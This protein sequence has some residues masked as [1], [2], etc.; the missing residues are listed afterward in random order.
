MRY[1]Y[2]KNYEDRNKDVEINNNDKVY[3]LIN[4]FNR[5]HKDAEINR[6]VVKML[7]QQI[8]SNEENE[9][10]YTNGPANKIQVLY[11]SKRKVYESIFNFRNDFNP[12]TVNNFEKLIV[13]MDGLAKTISNLLYDN[14]IKEFLE[15]TYKNDKKT[16]TSL[17]N[18][19]NDLITDYK[20]SCFNKIGFSNTNEYIESLNNTLK[21]G[22]SL[23]NRLYNN[24][25][26]NLNGKGGEAYVING[27]AKDVSVNDYL[28]LKEY[29]N[30]KNPI[31]RFFS[32]GT[33]SL[34]SQYE[35]KIKKMLDTT[36]DIDF[37]NYIN[38]N[39]NMSKKAE[40]Y[41][42]NNKLTKED[43]INF[44]K[45]L[46][47]ITKDLD[48]HEEKTNEKLNNMIFKS[49]LDLAKDINKANQKAKQKN[50]NSK[51]EVYDIMSSKDANE[52]KD[53][54]DKTFEQ[55]NNDLYEKLDKD[56][57][58]ATDNRKLF[59]LS[60]ND[61]AKEYDKEFGG[62][63][64]EEKQTELNNGTIEKINS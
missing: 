9:L 5:E 13:D 41:L 50:K 40:K 1:Q 64:T 8:E 57:K 11:Y 35:K 52:M 12:S 10:S 22:E 38:K 32:F 47:K 21:K 2:K 27:F 29:L 33:K 4:R 43:I 59:E 14:E 23:S 61:F 62:I 20:R 45:E 18:R 42:D 3:A 24:V 37:Q 28:A 48:L 63:P 16:E 60:N 39:A 53:K 7:L 26:K 17:N 25:K 55:Y 30:R 19:Y 31:A 58:E 36:S 49:D 15:R 51:I 34:L 46:D 44:T 54:I 56:S 6:S